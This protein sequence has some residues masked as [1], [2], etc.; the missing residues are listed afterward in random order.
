MDIKK[1]NNLTNKEIDNCIYSL[2]HELIRRE[3]IRKIELLRLMREDYVRC[4]YIPNCLEKIIIDTKDNRIIGLL[5]DKNNFLI[6][7]EKLI[8]SYTDI[9]CP[10][11]I[12]L[13]SIVV[14]I[15]L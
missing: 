14:D 15:N 4:G 6:G 5:A 11:N 10:Y 12:N 2:N 9:A 1:L 13:G 3:Y 8:E 7:L